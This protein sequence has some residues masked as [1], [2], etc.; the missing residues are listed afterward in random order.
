[1]NKKELENLDLTLYSKKLDNGLEVYIVPKNNINNI[2]VTFSTKYGSVQSEFVP[3]NETEMI[4]V[5]DGVAHFLEHKMFEQENKVDPFTFFSERG[6]DAN[7]NTSAYKTTYLFSGPDFFDENLNYLLDYVQSPYFT[8]KNV[9]KEKG[10]IEQEIKMYEDDPYSRLYEGTLFNSFK[11]HPIRKSAIGTVESISNINKEIL[12]KC[13]NTFYNPNNMFIVITGNVDPEKT[14]EIIEKNQANKTFDK[15]PK[16]ETK[17]YNEPDE[18]YK[19]EEVLNMNVSLPKITVSYKFNLDSL[20]DISRKEKIMYLSIIFDINFGST[21]LFNENLKQQKI[22]NSNLEISMVDTPNHA[23]YTIF[24]ETKDYERAI[25]LI[26]EEIKKM[27]ITEE[28]LE[29]KKKVAISSNVFMSDNIFSVNHKIM[30]DIIKYNKVMTNNHSTIK[31]LNI[32]DAKNILKA[33]NFENNSVFI[34]DKK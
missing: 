29:R 11:K 24:F 25:H 14:L 3:L 8:D 31:S 5:P 23:L 4:K 28:Q 26:E 32:K 30:N 15:L 9:E 1:M 7:A 27:T 13:Y 16:I 34:I 10:I 22:I 18:V 17:S 12:Y 21:S 2:Y 33:L 20:P 6:A 19:K